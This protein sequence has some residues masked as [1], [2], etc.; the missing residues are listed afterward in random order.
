MLGVTDISKST[1]SAAGLVDLISMGQE[2]KIILPRPG[3]QRLKFAIMRGIEHRG[4]LD[5]GLFSK[6]IA[7]PGTRVRNRIFDISR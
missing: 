2:D 3:I 5:N 4:G 7:A 6:V 1:V